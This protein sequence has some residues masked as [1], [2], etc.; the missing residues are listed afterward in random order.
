MAQSPGSSVAAA[1]R[2]FDTPAGLS[3]SVLQRHGCPLHYWLGGPVG[4]PLLAF[5]HGATMDHRMFNAQVEALIDQ[6]QVLVWDARGHGRSQ[7]L[8]EGFSLDRCAD[9]LL[10]VLDAIGATQAVLVGQSLGSYIAQYAYL[11]QPQ[12]VQAMVSIGS[13]CIALPYAAWEIIGLRLSL[14]LMKLWPYGSFTQTVAKATALRPDVRDYALL[15]IGQIERRD[16]LTIWQAVT[17]AVDKNGIPG[18]KIAVPL[19]LIHGDQDHTG[20]IRRQAPS[21]AAYEPDVRYVVIPDASHNANQD[22]PTFFNET[23]G[24]FLRERVAT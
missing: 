8:G 1:R 22:N 5:L 2:W 13:T 12:R 18:H 20:S 16:F 24:A 15:A 6:Y 14:P 3:G 19:L 9:D 23:L 17:L 11:R 21:W 10:V 7:P 4:R